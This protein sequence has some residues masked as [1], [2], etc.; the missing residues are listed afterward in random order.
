MRDLYFYHEL[1]DQYEELLN[2][3]HEVVRICDMKYD[4]GDVLRAVDPIAFRCGVS[5]W[6]G[7]DFE[8]LSYSDLTE[9]E[10]EHYIISERQA[11]YVRCEG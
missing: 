9:E 7:V 11:M 8:E 6:V 4:A 5:D 2:D 10:R 1:E 3:C